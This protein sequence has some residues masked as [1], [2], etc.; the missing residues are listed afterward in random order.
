MVLPRL[1]RRAVLLLGAV[2]P[3]SAAVLL[4]SKHQTTIFSPHTLS[5]TFFHN[6]PKQCFRQDTYMS[7]CSAQL[8]HI[9][10][11]HQYQHIRGKMPFQDR[12]CHPLPSTIDRQGPPAAANHDTTVEIGQVRVSPPARDRV[13]VSSRRRGNHRYCQANRALPG[14]A[15]GSKGGR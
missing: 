9:L 14:G 1:K 8:G 11:C 4:P 12:C 3:L 6:S 7:H 10:H 13:P 15:Q 2:L 5:S